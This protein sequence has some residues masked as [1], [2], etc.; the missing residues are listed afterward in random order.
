[1]EYTHRDST[2]KKPNRIELLG[3]EI[4]NLTMAETILRIEEFIGNKKSSMIF[5]PNVHRLV[6]AQKNSRIREIYF[7]ADLLIPDGMPLIWASRILKKPF[8]EKL[9]GSDLFPLFCEYAANK[10]H[11]IFLLGAKAG[12]AARAQEILTRKIL[13]SWQ[14]VKT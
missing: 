10:G 11:K 1:M 14:E 4:D 6:S 12:I 13:E 2:Y 8:R 9:S 7:S 5:T 3:I